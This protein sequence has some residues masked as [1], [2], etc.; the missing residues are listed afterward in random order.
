[1][2]GVISG[3]SRKFEN[4]IVLPNGRKLATL[5]DAGEYIHSLPKAT[6][7]TAPWQNAIEALLLVVKQ[8]GPTMSARP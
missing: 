6:Q 7:Q 2:A 5:L 8:N 1:M 3:W 4:P